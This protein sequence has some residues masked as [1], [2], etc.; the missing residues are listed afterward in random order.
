[1]RCAVTAPWRAPRPAYTYVCAVDCG[2]HGTVPHLSEPH[3]LAAIPVPVLQP[4]R[5]PVHPELV[6]QR[7]RDGVFGEDAK[8]GAAHAAGREEEGRRG[9]LL[10]DQ[11][12]EAGG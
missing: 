8:P 5:M 11:V 3:S 6:H 2:D 4:V 1:M 10:G 7:L 9:Y 12:M